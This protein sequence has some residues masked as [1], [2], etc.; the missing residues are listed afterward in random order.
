VAMTIKAITPIKINI[1]PIE[2]SLFIIVGVV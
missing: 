1:S 2:Y